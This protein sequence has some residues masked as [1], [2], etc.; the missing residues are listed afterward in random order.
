VVQEVDGAAEF[1]DE[2][3]EV[4]LEQHQRVSDGGSC[5]HTGL[6]VW[7]R[8][9]AACPAQRARGAVGT[10]HVAREQR[11][12]AIGVDQHFVAVHVNAAHFHSAPQPD[13]RGS[14]NSG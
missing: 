6:I 8:G 10:Y 14:G 4:G 13:R 5:R 1:C 3:G 2:L 11:V 12:V 7:P 9:W